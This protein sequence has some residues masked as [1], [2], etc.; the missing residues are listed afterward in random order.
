MFEQLDDPESFLP[1]EAFRAKVHQRARTIRRRRRA[2]RLAI[3]CGAAASL[4]AIVVALRPSGNGDSTQIIVTANN[5]SAANTAEAVTSAVE[6]SA[7]TAAASVAVSAENFLVVGSDGRDCIDPDGPYAGAFLGEG[8][9]IGSRSDTM[10]LIRVDPAG[11]TAMLSF[12]RDLW[13]TIAGSNGKSRINAAFDPDNPLKLIDTIKLNFGLSVDHYINVDF[14]GFKDI[15][16]AVGGVAVPF[17]YATRDRNTGLNIE[18]PECH[19]LDGNEALAYVRSRH[20]EYFDPSKNQWVTDGTSDYGRIT[21]QQDFVKRT[22]AKFL[23]AIQANPL[24]ATDLIDAAVRNVITDKELTV[25][26]ML[27]FSKALAGTDAF[28][29]RHFQIEGR[30]RQVGNASVIE[31]TLDTPLMSA[32]LAIFRGDAPLADEATREPTNPAVTQI[33]TNSAPDAP[34]ENVSM[35][36]YPPD[37]PSCR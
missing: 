23:D 16:D 17:E 24:N 14:C 31:P 9:D 33:S 29:I 1:N 13:V 28:A 27:D 25:D 37:D 18:Q 5:D 12:P 32:V 20:Y 30:G 10:M 21:R 15:V 36:I 2:Q 34:A 7:S 22:I 8:D 11:Q 35:G 19:T 3:G 4:S 6:T 26:T